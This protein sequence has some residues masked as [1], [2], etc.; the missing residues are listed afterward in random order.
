[1]PQTRYPHD[2]FISYA[3]KDNESS[4]HGE[5]G[6]VT[7]FKDYLE[8][9][10]I[11]KRHLKDITIW[12]DDEDLSGN[13]MFD[14]AIQKTIQNTALFFVLHSHNYQ[15]SDYCRKEL[16]WFVK[17]N[18]NNLIVNQRSRIFNVLINNISHEDW[19]EDFAG[20]TGFTL[21]D[22]E[23]QD[24]YGYPT[25]PR[26]VEF[27]QQMRKLVEDISK[28]LEVLPKAEQAADQTESHPESGDK[29]Q[30]FLAE[31]ADTLR[32]FRKR[33]IQ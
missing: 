6:W 28:V 27:N 8:N 22:A 15:D 5:D 23:A 9:W 7:Q 25:D 2:I 14:E 31:V 3:R 12:M 20:T 19:A 1:M 16:D 21:H 17:H 29:P 11:K 32:P 13:A 30:I 26:T 33:L 24:Q 10:L 18:P 4:P